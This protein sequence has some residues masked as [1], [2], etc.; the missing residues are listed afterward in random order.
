M[1]IALTRGVSPRIAEC[2]LTH[3]AREPIR[4]ERA[5]AQHAAYERALAELG[6]SVRR[7]AGGGEWPDSVFIEDTA[8]VLPEAAVVTRPG[9]RARRAETAEVAEV[10]A[11]HRPVVSIEPPGTLD[12]GDVLRVGRAIYVGLSGRSNRDAIGQLADL[13]RP[14]GYTVKGVPVAGC[15]HLKSAVTEVASGTLLLNPAWVDAGH[16]PGLRVL[17]V[18]PAEPYA[19]NAVR[20]GS[21]V[22]FPTAFPRT[23]ARLEAAGIAVHAVDVSELAKA[24]GALTCCSLI[25]RDGEVAGDSRAR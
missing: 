9:A 13:V 25:F 4:V 8:I 15:L 10:L 1:L 16:F 7:L 12:G 6:C 21:G 23:R 14:H 24:E 2:E 19:A 5:Q 11:R 17:E 20:I 3:L 22:V 18:D